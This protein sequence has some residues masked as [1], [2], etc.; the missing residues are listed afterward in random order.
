MTQAEEMVEDMQDL[1][2]Q[3]DCLAQE[4]GKAEKEWEKMCRQVQDLRSVVWGGIEK[5]EQDLKSKKEELAQVK[6]RKEMLESSG[7][8][9]R[10]SVRVPGMSKGASAGPS[11]PKK[12]KRNK[13]K[14][15]GL[16]SQ[17]RQEHYKSYLVHL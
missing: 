16:P 8:A 13:Q 7:L 15:P 11:T 3:R 6:T 2:H 9:P 14:N 5:L 17:E 10:V 4:A 1:C 12:K